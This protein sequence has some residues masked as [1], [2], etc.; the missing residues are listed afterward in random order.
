MKKFKVF[1]PATAAIMVFC[2]FFTSINQPANTLEAYWDDILESFFAQPNR[3]TAKA[4]FPDTSLKMQVEDPYQ[5]GKMMWVYPYRQCNTSTSYI[6]Y[7]FYIPLDSNAYWNWSSFSYDKKVQDR[8]KFLFGKDI[9]AKRFSLA[10]K[11]PWDG[12]ISEF[13]FY[14]SDAIDQAFK[15]LYKK[16]SKK[17]K[18]LRLQKIYDIALKEYCR[19]AAA[20]VAKVK[21][22]DA[23]FVELAKKYL[24]G[25]EKD[26]TFEGQNFSAEAAR[27]LKTVEAA[28]TFTCMHAYMHERI[29]GIM[30][31]RQCDGS[32]PVLLSWFKTI[33]KDY[34]PDYFKTISAKF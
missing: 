1:I 7:S 5:A 16:P 18:G 2:S 26:T 13:R 28:G 8:F 6:Y 34:D 31:R 27:Q 23:A 10:A 14:N 11:S 15:K 24:A 17:F 3:W 12:E 20:V 30:L 21:S 33:L 25:A 29:V 4:D 9:I 32:L 19:D 22:Q